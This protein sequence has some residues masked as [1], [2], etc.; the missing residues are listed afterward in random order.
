MLFVNEGM[1]VDK[2]RNERI[3][4][5][6][7]LIVK[8][9]KAN[10]STSIHKKESQ[11]YSTVL[12]FCCSCF[13]GNGVIAGWENDIANFPHMVNNK[14]KLLKI[15]FSTNARMKLRFI[16]FLLYKCNLTIGM[17]FRFA[18][19]DLFLCSRKVMCCLDLVEKR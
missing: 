2:K 6:K 19:N 7:M 17:L 4:H 16:Y 9:W 8:S 14:K 3:F 18:E 15:M 5:L 1:I 11:K 10:T 12:F 13:I